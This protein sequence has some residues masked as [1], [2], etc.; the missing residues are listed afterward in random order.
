MTLVT[1]TDIQEDD[2]ATPDLWNT[3][4][5]SIVNAINGNLD[6]SNL[7]DNAVSTNKITNLAVTSAKLATDAV[8][9]AKIPDNAVTT[10]KIADSNVTTAKIADANV[11][12]PK[13][14]NPYKFSVYRNAALTPGANDVVFDTE[15]YDH[16]N[17]FSTVTGRYTAPVTGYY[18]FAATLTFTFTSSGVGVG[19]GLRKNG[20]TLLLRGTTNVVMYTGTFDAGQTISGIVSL[21]AGDTIGIYDVAVS[22]K[23]LNPAPTLCWFQGMLVSTT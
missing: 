6:S 9:T 11:T 5:S 2:A 4:F 1:Y 14:T 13:L 16:N 12:V 10:V 21:T 20:V 8:A 22:N 23:P 19:I 7:A 3:R 15:L 18:W 17:N